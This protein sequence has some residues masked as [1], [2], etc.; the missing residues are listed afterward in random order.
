MN[1]SIIIILLIGLLFGD[2]IDELE[3][4]YSHGSNVICN[5]S[6]LYKDNG[7]WYSKSQ[8]APYTGRVEIYEKQGQDRIE[9]KSIIENE[10]NGPRNQNNKINRNYKIAECTIV[11]GYKNGIYIQY[12]RDHLKTISIAGLYINDNKEGTWSWL[13]PF[14]ANR[15]KPWYEIDDF[16]I[17]TIEYHSG[18]KHGTIKVYKTDS[19]MYAENIAN[20]QYTDDVL[21][22]RGQYQEGFRIGEWHFFDPI[23]DNIE[24]S[25][26]YFELQKDEFNPYFWTREYSYYNNELINKECRDNWEGNI[27]CGSFED[28]YF[29]KLYS[30]D[31]LDKSYIKVEQKPSGNMAF[32]KDRMGIE[33]EI[34]VN[35]FLAHIA[36][37]HKSRINV[38]KQDGF[39]FDINDELRDTLRELKQMSN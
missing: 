29:D 31:I 18:V 5:P 8:K 26:V 27:D 20:H 17:T 4:L 21:M 2:E 6:D 12:L 39:S 1:K 36:K 19:F 13:E 38:H 37:Y 14:E 16:I 24:M 30:V 23:I 7:I 3:T 15:T 11:D 25:R 33:R 9:L 34:D 35:L 10:K 32:I 28:K 22:L